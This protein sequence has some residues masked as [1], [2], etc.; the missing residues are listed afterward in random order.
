M[1]KW[2]R[3][4]VTMDFWQSLPGVSMALDMGFRHMGSSELTHSPLRSEA[5]CVVMPY[6]YM[7]KRTWVGMLVGLSS[8]QTVRYAA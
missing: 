6:S 1:A 8:L 3:P 5:L 4:N 7:M 2:R